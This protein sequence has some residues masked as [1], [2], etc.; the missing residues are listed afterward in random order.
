MTL[1]KSL[2]K[3]QIGLDVTIKTIS[4]VLKARVLF[5]KGIIQGVKDIISPGFYS[6]KFQRFIRKRFAEYT[7]NNHSPFT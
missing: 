5:Y 4:A 6:L 2:G 1:A 7:E 3:R